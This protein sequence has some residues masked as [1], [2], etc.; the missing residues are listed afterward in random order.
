M[1]PLN[2][3]AACMMVICGGREAAVYTAPARAVSANTGGCTTGS[4]AAQRVFR[5]H[6]PGDRLPAALLNYICGGSGAAWRRSLRSFTNK[7]AP[8]PSF[9]ESTFE[10]KQSMYYT[11]Q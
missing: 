6:T 7:Q 2:R 11:E 5:S 4:A 9:L 1:L 8:R 3:R 10:R